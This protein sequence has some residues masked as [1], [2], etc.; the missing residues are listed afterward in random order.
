MALLFQL[1]QS[2]WWTPQDIKAKQL[3]QLG[4][5]V[6][7]AS[8]TIPYYNKRLK[9]AGLDF[10]GKITEKQWESIPLLRREDI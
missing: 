8:D 3:H 5:L 1:E 7:H 9:E 10:K 2:Q 4:H 6:T